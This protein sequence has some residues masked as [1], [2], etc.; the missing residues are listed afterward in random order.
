[1]SFS[2]TIISGLIVAPVVALLAAS[3]PLPA[4]PGLTPF[5][6][7]DRVLRTVNAVPT[8]ASLGAWH[9]LLGSEPHVAGTDGDLREIARIQAAFVGMGITTAVEEFDALLPQPTE[10]IVEIVGA[11]DIAQP[12]D[13]S[14]R[15]VIALPTVERNLAEDPATAHPGLTFGWNAYSATGDVTA[16]V[17]YANYGTK[18]DFAKLKELGVDCTGKVVLAR[19]G[20]NFRGY[21]VKFAEEAGAAAL[22]IYTDPADTGVTKGKVWPAGGWA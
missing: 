16:G 4:P 17:V 5:T 7:V 12:V 10:G 11:T 1:M 2:L 15:G 3:A 9:E 19:Y 22:I 6:P 20:G 21:K 8:A 13:G 14:R 18:A